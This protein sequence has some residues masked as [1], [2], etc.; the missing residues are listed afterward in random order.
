MSNKVKVKQK[1]IKGLEK[2]E[3]GDKSKTDFLVGIQ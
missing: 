2:G 1:Q 3:E